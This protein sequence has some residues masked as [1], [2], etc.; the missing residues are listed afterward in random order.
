MTQRKV[1]H[2]QRGAQLPLGPRGQFFP[3]PLT[4]SHS[5]NMSIPRWRQLESRNWMSKR[6]SAKAACSKSISEALYFYNLR[7]LMSHK[8]KIFNPKNLPSTRV[9]S[10]WLK[11]LPDL[12]NF[13]R[14][15]RLENF[16]LLDFLLEDFLL[17]EVPGVVGRQVVMLS[18]AS[19]DWETS[20]ISGGTS[21][22]STF[23]SVLFREKIPTK[24]FQNEGFLFFFDFL[25]GFSGSSRIVSGSLA[26]GSTAENV[27]ISSSLNPSAKWIEGSLE[28][29][30]CFLGIVTH[31]SFLP[32]FLSPRVPSFRLRLRLTYTSSRRIDS[33][34]GTD[35]NWP[36]LG[37]WFSACVSMDV[38]KKKKTTH[39]LFHIKRVRNHL[40]SKQTM[41]I[42]E[43]GCRARTISDRS[44][45]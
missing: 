1:T 20:G 23:S 5:M 24:F 28:C 27:P 2:H 39:I 9:M 44:I 35:I 22:S 4:P 32:T 26:W 30:L 40:C 41:S 37:L 15:S 17:C 43:E 38:Y 16:L 10:A 29:R 6:T 14:E 34:W 7:V 19:S 12:L 18:E 36:L 42:S 45:T 8:V 11:S 31:F 33:L 3:V 25:V 21:S 13:V